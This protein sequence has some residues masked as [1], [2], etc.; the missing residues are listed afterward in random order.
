MKR[1]TRSDDSG[2]AMKAASLKALANRNTTSTVTLPVG[3]VDGEELDRV[4]K[5]LNHQNS[6]ENRNG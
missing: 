6:K 2:A 5:S 1:L 4:L 3:V